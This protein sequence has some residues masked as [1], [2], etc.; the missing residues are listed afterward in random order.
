V[1][2][3]DIADSAGKTVRSLLYNACH[4]SALLK[5]ISQQ[6]A[7]VRAF[8]F[9]CFCVSCVCIL[10][11]SVF[12]LR[13]PRL[14][15]CTCALVYPCKVLPSGNK[16]AQKQ[17]ICIYSPVKLWRC[18]FS[19]W[20]FAVVVISASL[21]D[22]DMLRRTTAESGYSCDGRENASYAN[23]VRESDAML[24]SPCVIKCNNSC[25]RSR[26]KYALSQPVRVFVYV[27]DFWKSNCYNT[28]TQN[29]TITSLTCASQVGRL[30]WPV[31]DLL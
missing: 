28:S 18:W 26:H 4:T 31:I 7:L 3:L 13:R 1:S 2:L 24:R 27:V 12:V 16:H 17:Y 19:Y 5:W 14:H 15:C 22:V 23:S 9:V 10:L 21:H 8:I 20:L 29:A 25:L 30:P 11:S 6:K